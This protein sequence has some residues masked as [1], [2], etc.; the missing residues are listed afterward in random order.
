MTEKDRRQGIEFGE[1]SDSMASLNYPVNHDDLLR[2]HGDAELHLPTGTTTLREV[3][4][5]LQDEDHTYRDEEELKTMIVNTVGDG[6]IGRKNYSDR[7]PPGLG[8][9]RPDEGA[10]GQSVDDQESI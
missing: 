10:P 5:T 8:E 3:L 9:E 2:Q 1:F 6:A 4:G 7:D